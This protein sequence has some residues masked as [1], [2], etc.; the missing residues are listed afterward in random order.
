PGGPGPAGRAG[1]AAVVVRT[2]AATAS[3]GVLRDPRPDAGVRRARP[4]A[5]AAGVPLRRAHDRLRAHAGHRDGRRP[6]RRL[7]RAAVAVRSQGAPATGARTRGGIAP[8]RRD[9]PGW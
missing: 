9:G 4:R 7:S 5:A 2:V 6:S 3:G 8:W 1:P